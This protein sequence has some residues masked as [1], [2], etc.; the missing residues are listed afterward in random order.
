MKKIF[1]LFSILGVFTVILLVFPLPVSADE[2]SEVLS[3]YTLTGEE[4]DKFEEQEQIQRNMKSAFSIDSEKL[5][6]DYDAL[7]ETGVL[8]E[9][10][11]FE[12]YLELATTPPPSDPVDPRFRSIGGRPQPG[13]IFITNGTSL[14][15]LTGHAGIFLGNGTI[16]SIIG[17]G[18]KPEALSIMDWTERYNSQKGTWTK[19]YRPAAKYRPELAEQWAINNYKGKNYSYKITTN[20]FEKNPTYC[21]KIVWQAYW[22]SS[23]AVQIGGFHTPIIA[24][25]YDLPDYFE[26]RPAHVVTWSPGL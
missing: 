25:P 14:G 18:A 13:D 8:G 9:D 20:I 1:Q 3:K 10:I 6:Q 5:E 11:T 15:G 16:L 22:Y 2:V 17:P 12:M 23:A 7:Q 26:T 24:S 4:L 21:S 19:I